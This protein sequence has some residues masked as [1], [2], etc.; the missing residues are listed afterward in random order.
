MTPED[1][2]RI[3]RTEAEYQKNIE[4]LNGQ[5][6]PMITVIVIIGIVLYLVLH[7]VP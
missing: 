2:Q 6:L 7:G 5:E 4:A 1:L 3:L